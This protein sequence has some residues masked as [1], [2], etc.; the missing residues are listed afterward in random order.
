[1]LEAISRLATGRPN[2]IVAGLFFFA[3]ALA[4]PAHADS[5]QDQDFYRLL[6]E[7]DQDRP[8]MIWNFAE[9]RAEGIAVCQREDEG[10]PPYES[11]KYLERPN[12][13]YAFD[14]ANSIA[15]AAETVYCPW[16]NAPTGANNWV[17][18]SAPV[19][20]LPVYPPIEWYPPPPA[21]YPPGG[22]QG[23]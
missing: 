2:K 8:M 7:P 18:T 12:G 1:M 14:D 20:P 15:S 11:M 17:E 22:G 6:T 4:A 3:V 10:V 21:Y 23:Y 16:H 9:V 13:P 19:N 5:K